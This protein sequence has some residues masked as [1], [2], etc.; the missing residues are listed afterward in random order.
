M[1]S[2]CH[3]GVPAFHKLLDGPAHEYLYRPLAAGSDRDKA[4]ACQNSSA[5]CFAIV[6]YNGKRPWNAPQNVGDLFGSNPPKDMLPYLPRHKHFLLDISRFPK[7]AL[8]KLHG[9]AAHIVKL[10]REKAI[11]PLMKVYK[12]LLSQIQGPG[13]ADVR[14]SFTHGFAN[15]CSRKWI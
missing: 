2:C 13:Y 10:E 4:T 3:A 14:V 11:T 7:E 6:I 15:I 1:L 5:H 8:D 9:V 12:E